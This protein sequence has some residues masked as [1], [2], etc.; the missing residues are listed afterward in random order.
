MR[1]CGTSVLCQYEQLISRLGTE[2]REVKRRD[3]EQRHESTKAMNRLKKAK[4]ISCV[5]RLSSKVEIA[6][7]KYTT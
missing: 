6:A 1:S 7:F 2:G 4:M 3:L 5:G